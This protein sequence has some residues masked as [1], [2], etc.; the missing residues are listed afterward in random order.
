[1]GRT[2]ARATRAFTLLEVLITI[3]LV[4]A[5]TAI[6]WSD[7]RGEERMR[8]LDES[9]RRFKTLIAMCRAEAMNEAV[10]VRIAIRTDGALEVTRQ[11]EPLLA[12]HAYV[13]IQTDWARE[14]VLL[15]DVWI[16]SVTPLDNGLTPIRVDDE[17]ITL[18]DYEP[19]PIRVEDLASAMQVDFQ[20]DGLSGS[21]E[22]VLRTTDG[23]GMKLTLDGR[24]GRV[25]IET[26]EAIEAE[27]VV[28][29]EAIEDDYDA[30][31]EARLLEELKDAQPQ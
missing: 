9:A 2:R 14:P 27:T 4:A 30:E 11:A 28:R 8:R 3:A 17:L 29:P 20:P 19:E 18:D 13:R 24:V 31:A 5:L 23:K 1:M 26:V 12:P 22:C 10:G 15:T 25:A 6:V 7:F 21:L 16:E